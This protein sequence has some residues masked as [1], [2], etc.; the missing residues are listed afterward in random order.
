MATA[1][2]MTESPSRVVDLHSFSLREFLEFVCKEDTNWIDGAQVRRS[3]D[4]H[5]NAGNVE[6][7]VWLEVAHA[8][9]FASVGST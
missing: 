6:G 7:K 2:I 9:L 3:D 8:P 1:G 5:E 4:H